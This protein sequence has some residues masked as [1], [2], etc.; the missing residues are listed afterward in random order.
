M[1]PT[2]TAQAA[3]K[4]LNLLL[5]LFRARAQHADG[6][7]HYFIVQSSGIAILRKAE[8]VLSR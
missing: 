3:C 4:I 1:R 2:G 7:E 6:D 8:I 5:S